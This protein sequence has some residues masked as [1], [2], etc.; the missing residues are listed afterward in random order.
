MCERSFL[1]TSEVAIFRSGINSVDPSEP[2]KVLTDTAGNHA[3]ADGNHRAYKGYMTGIE[4][5][6]EII[7]RILKDISKDPYYHP[8]SE[9][10][11]IEK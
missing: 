10:K 2:I 8:I 9:L 11:I 6:R 3:L 7:G 4:V 5:K 1:Y